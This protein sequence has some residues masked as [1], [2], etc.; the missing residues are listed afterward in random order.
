MNTKTNIK[1]N[2]SIGLDG[3]HSAVI[4]GAGLNGLAAAYELKRRGIDPV[5]LDGAKETAAPWRKRHHGLRLN[6]HRLIS[7]LPGKRIPRKYGP[8]PR[9]DDMVAY[10]DDYERALDVPVHRGVWIERIDP[11]PEGWRLTTASG[12]RRARHVIVATG[13]ER[14]PVVPA[15]PGR[16]GFTSELIHSADFGRADRFRDRRVLVVGAGNSGVDVLNHLSREATGAL[17]VS[18]RNGPT[19]L[20][21]R[22]LGFPLQ[23]LSPLMVPLPAWAVDLMMAATERL[24]LGDLRKLGLSN[25]PDGVA[26]RLIREGVAPAFDDGFVAALKVGR[27]TVLP[28]VSR[29]DGDAVILSDGTEI[30]PDAVICATGYRP[31]L[32]GLVGHLGVLDGSG[33]PIHPG[34]IPHP[35]HTG[36]WFMG[37]TPRLPGVFYAARGEA[38]RLARRIRRSL[39]SGEKRVAGPRPAFSL[40]M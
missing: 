31:G 17:W 34:P 13:N 22:A 24:F 27:V 2:N 5:I 32:E 6:T 20:P 14:R 21:T 3:V 36:L 25:H 23:L 39:E 38:R 18:V 12:I 30:R 4:V 8:F 37:M 40:G 1:E 9:R 16:E 33:R 15:W 26:T 19:V 11:D 29:F 28:A 10:L 35:D 7:H